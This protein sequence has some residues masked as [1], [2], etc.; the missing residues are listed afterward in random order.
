MLLQANWKEKAF[1]YLFFFFSQP[2][3]VSLSFLHLTLFS[4]IST[5]VSQFIYFRRKLL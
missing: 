3:Y 4:K 5:V 2:F 1:I